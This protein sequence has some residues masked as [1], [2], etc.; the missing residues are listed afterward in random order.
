MLL[1]AKSQPYFTKMKFPSTLSFALVLLCHA[2]ISLSEGTDAND[3]I[4]DRLIKMST[5]LDKLV[6]VVTDVVNH[7][8]KTDDKMASIDSKVKHVNS[9]MTMVN[10]KVSQ[11]GSKMATME[12]KM[13]GMAKSVGQNKNHVD[14]V[15]RSMKENW[16]QVTQ[17]VDGISKFMAELKITKFIGFGTSVTTDDHQLLTVTSMEEC[18]ETCLKKR[19]DAGPAWNGVTYWKDNG[20]PMQCQCLKNDQGHDVSSKYQHMLHF[21]FH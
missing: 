14:A 11:I 21:R 16:K 9:E 19:R 18:L 6:N 13:N 2:I 4:L 12:S 1:D 10:S 15:E 5:K 17:S 20:R 8:K 3:S 7:Q